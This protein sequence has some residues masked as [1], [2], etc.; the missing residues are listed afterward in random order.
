MRK[1][2]KFKVGKLY[3]LRRHFDDLIHERIPKGTIL[4]FNSES[5]YLYEFQKAKE[6]GIVIRIPKDLAYK[7]LKEAK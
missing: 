5:R 1:N 4:R 7:I 3:E 2:K 6:P